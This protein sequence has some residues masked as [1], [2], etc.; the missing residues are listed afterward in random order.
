MKLLDISDEYYE[1]LQSLELDEDG[2]LIGLDRLDDIAKTL[3]EKVENTALYIKELRYEVEALRNEERILAERRR[4]K[5]STAEWLKN[6][7][8][9]CM[10]LVGQNRYESN[11]VKVRIGSSASVNVTDVNKL[12]E[13]YVRVTTK[14]E[15]DKNAIKDAIKAGIEVAGASLETKQNLQIK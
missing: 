9:G 10:T 5:E 4:S 8:I 3:G 13:E 6:Y 14:F 11:K 1:V 7:L 2:D 15:P 12:P